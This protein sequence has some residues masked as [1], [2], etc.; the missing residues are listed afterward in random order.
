MLRHLMSPGALFTLL[1][2]AAAALAVWLC[3]LGSRRARRRRHQRQES[4]AELCQRLELLA[5]PG[6]AGAMWG[7]LA[8]TGFGLRDTGAELV[9]EVPLSRPLLPPGLVLLSAQAP[10]PGGRSPLSP[11][12]SSGTVAGQPVLQWYAA[13]EVA[14]GVLEVPPAF[15]EAALRAHHAVAPFRLEPERLVRYLPAETLPSPTAVRES[16]QAL[17]RAAEQW[18]RAV[19]PEEGPTVREA[20]PAS[21]ARPPFLP[22][23]RDALE[24]RGAWQALL[25]INGGLPLA[26]LALLTKVGWLFMAVFILYLLFVMIYGSLR[27]HAA[28]VLL[29]GMAL[30]A[31][32]GAPF[33]W[34]RLRELRASPRA[35]G[36]SVR[37]AAW[38]RDTLLFRFRDGTP[39]EDLGARVTHTG[40][41]RSGHT[42]RSTYEVT[43]VVPD[44]WTPDEP[45]ALWVTRSPP[46]SVRPGTLAGVREDPLFVGHYREAAEAAAQ[47]HGLKVHEQALFL[48][49]GR[50]P[51]GAMARL[52]REAPW[53]LGVPNLLWLGWALLLCGGALREH[54]R[55]TPR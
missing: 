16:V 40:R 10:L 44:G 51:D 31:S 11:R 17:Q 26:L 35:E 38:H 8:G 28:G 33:M 18:T 36:I 49:I 20:K 55:S 24:E 41:D 5:E 50:E 9:L 27:F 13:P 48:D 12:A 29:A 3:F 23:L 19:K 15:Q 37:E 47:Q 7:R 22:A 1:L 53:F 32:F 42:T 14:P 2:C 52:E 25:L 21:A 43:P 39:R 46:T 6:E 30:F 34:L 54:W 4:W 45:V